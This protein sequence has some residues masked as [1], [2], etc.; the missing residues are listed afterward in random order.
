M[1]AI[2]F[3]HTHPTLLTPPGPV[4]LNTSKFISSFIILLNPVSF[5]HVW[6]GLGTSIGALSTYQDHTL[7]N[8]TSSWL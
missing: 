6:V 4:P 8:A 7:K 3:D 2:Y 1:H 5:A